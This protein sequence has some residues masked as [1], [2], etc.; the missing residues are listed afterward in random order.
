MKWLDLLFLTN[1]QEQ[2]EYNI[3]IGIIERGMER[4]GFR[5]RKRKRDRR[6]VASSVHAYSL[7]LSLSLLLYL[8]TIPLARWSG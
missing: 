6:S 4:G 1:G 8:P 2:P 7:P 5:Y 3:I